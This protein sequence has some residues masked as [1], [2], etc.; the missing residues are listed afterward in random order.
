MT[1]THRCAI[2]EVKSKGQKELRIIDTL[3]PVL[4]SHKLLVHETVIAKDFQSALNPDGTVDP[5]YSGFHQ[6]TRITKDRGA[7][8]HDDRLD[9]LAIGVAFFTE[10]LEKDSELGAQE[11]LADFLEEQMENPLMGFETAMSLAVSDSINMTW[12]DDESFGGNY[13]NF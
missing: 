6:L 13:V 12:E 3:E 2:T 1:R 11:M 9:A 10:S 4:G 8:K 5:S 7:L